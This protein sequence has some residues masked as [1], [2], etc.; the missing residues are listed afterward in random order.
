MVGKSEG[1]IVL[2]F[3]RSII[4]KWLNALYSITSVFFINKCFLSRLFSY[5]ILKV[6]L[7]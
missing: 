1:S 7:F 6:L 3:F 5:K 2:G 4:L